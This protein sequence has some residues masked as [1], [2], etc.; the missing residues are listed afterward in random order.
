MMKLAKIGIAS[1]VLAT[2]SLAAVT[3]AAARDNTGVA[4]VAGIIGLGLGAAIA[5]D[6][7]HYRPTQYY[8]GA[9]QV[10]HPQQGYGYGNGYNNGYGYGSGYAYGNGYNSSERYWAQRRAQ[11]ARQR[12]WERQRYAHRRDRDDDDG[13]GYDNRGY[14]YGSGY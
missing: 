13:Y 6:H 7:P 4:V 2:S 1:A 14:G 9:P 5:S 12:Q 8:D 11:E 10:Y 3:P